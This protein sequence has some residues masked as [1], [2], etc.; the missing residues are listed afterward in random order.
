MGQSFCVRLSQF[1]KQS[2]VGTLTIRFAQM[3]GVNTP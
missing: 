2:I 3:N 1:S